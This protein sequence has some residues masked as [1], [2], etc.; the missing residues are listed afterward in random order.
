MLMYP[1]EV[2]VA[3]REPSGENELER[4]R[5]GRRRREDCWCVGADVLKT[6]NFFLS[7]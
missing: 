5:V 4:T 7:A 6:N 3:S 2:Q 1:S